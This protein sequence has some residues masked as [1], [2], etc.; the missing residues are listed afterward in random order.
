MEQLAREGNG[1]LTVKEAQARLKCGHNA[2]YRLYKRGL[3]R[4]SK[5][6]HVGLRIYEASLVE[7]LQQFSN[8]RP[9]EV[10]K[11]SPRPAAAKR[12]ASRV[13]FEGIV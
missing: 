2:V 11:P 4:G 6:P 13:Y 8:E 7:L 1:L 10:L 9:P 3:L 5:P 12:K